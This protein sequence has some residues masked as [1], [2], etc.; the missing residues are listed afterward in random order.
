M[1]ANDP[2]V[3]VLVIFV[4]VLAMVALLVIFGVD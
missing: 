3:F 2:A 1:S 4:A